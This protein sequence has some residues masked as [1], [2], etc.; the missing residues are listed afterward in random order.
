[1]CDYTN[2]KALYLHFGLGHQR[3]TERKDIGVVFRQQAVRCGDGAAYIVIR[4]L[5]KILRAPPSYLPCF[6]GFDLHLVHFRFRC[7]TRKYI[8][9]AEVEKL[10]LEEPPKLPG[11]AR[12]PML[13]AAYAPI[14]SLEPRKSKCVACAESTAA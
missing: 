4:E 5:T 14:I 8:N 7:I 11:L 12:V 1:M 2:S 6:F 3:L 10:K 13:C 9:G